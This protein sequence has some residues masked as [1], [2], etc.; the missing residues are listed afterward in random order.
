VLTAVVN[1]GASL[2]NQDLL[3][4][5]S[6]SPSSW[7]P[8]LRP[9]VSS[10]GLVLEL[11]LLATT[12][13]STAGKGPSGAFAGMAFDSCAF[14][15]VVGQTGFASSIFSSPA[16]TTWLS[17]EPFGFPFSFSTFSGVVGTSS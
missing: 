2:L 5:P 1:N 9:A 10:A 15:E 11:L 13:R 4:T 8:Q 16:A 7:Q 14:R 17:G 6:T 12:P 3:P